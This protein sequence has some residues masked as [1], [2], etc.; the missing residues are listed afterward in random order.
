M[1]ISIH[2]PTRNRAGELATLLQALRTQDYQDFDVLILDDRSN[3]PI[4]N[5]N[6]I[7]S[8]VNRLKLEG[9]VVKIFR[10]DIPGNVCDMR[11]KLIE[12]DDLGNGLICRLDDDVVPERNYL[13]LLKETIDRGWDLAS[14]VTPPM[15]APDVFREIRFVKPVI[16]DV[17]FNDKGDVI[18]NGDDCGF[19]YV[20][21][22][23]IPT[24]HFR[25][26]A[27]YKAEINKTIRYEKNVTFFREEEFF[28]FRMILAGYKLAV[29]TGA[30]IYHQMPLSGGN[31]E[32][33][34]Q[35]A[36][37]Q[38]EETFKIWCKRLFEK[39]GDFI[40]AYRERLR[41][42]GLI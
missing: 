21:K 4:Q 7:V 18:K 41:K 38:D 19:N 36:V 10:N 42:E 6:I 9:H 2:I 22:E 29:H 16:N 20:E 30:I 11:N 32:F 28:S 23:I 37:M 27:L 5:H 25:S 13:R 35:A 12:L 31:K 24:P 8:Q 15:A 33:N 40:Q 26:C 3:T 1:R 17:I 14:G 39:N 34:Y